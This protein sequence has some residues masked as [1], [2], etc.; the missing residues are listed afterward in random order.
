MSGLTLVGRIY[1]RARKVST[2]DGSS[3]VKQLV[4]VRVSLTR[5]KREDGINNRSTLLHVAN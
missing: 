2:R 1:T 3:D 4:R 5:L